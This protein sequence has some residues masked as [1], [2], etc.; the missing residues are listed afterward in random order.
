MHASIGKGRD[1]SAG[2][3]DIARQSRS[4]RLGALDRFL[5]ARI[6]ESTAASEATSAS[7]HASAVDGEGISGAPATSFPKQ[8]CCPPAGGGTL[9]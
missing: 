7:L 8:T 2:A 4:D 1:T 6:D 3:C 5:H 9:L